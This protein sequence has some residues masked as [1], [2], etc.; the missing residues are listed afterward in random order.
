MSS[1][2]GWAVIGIL[3]LILALEALRF[4]SLRSIQ[5]SN[6]GTPAAK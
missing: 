5:A 2:Q 4:L 3:S 6:M 1:K